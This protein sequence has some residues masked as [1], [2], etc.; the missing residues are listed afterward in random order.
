[1]DL[2]AQ[3][4]QERMQLEPWSQRWID[5]WIAETHLEA[6][7]LRIK[8]GIVRCGCS[9]CKQLG[10][11]VVGEAEAV[12]VVPP[13]LPAVSPIPSTETAAAKGRG[14]PRT[15]AVC[16]FCN[17]LVPP[18]NL[19]YWPGWEEGNIPPYWA[20]LR[21]Y[22]FFRDNLTCR[23]CHKKFPVDKLIARHII[24]KEKGGFD[25]AYNLH[26][27]CHECH[28]VEAETEEAGGAIPL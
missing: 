19:G 1:M 6:E 22:V 4:H 26:T 9:L 15:R 16:P 23:G 14:R 12:I 7:L 3:L 28:P 17:S 27:Y 18:D 2:V 5:L 11:V 21:L 13:L 10:S 20:T 8:Q 24:P 25:A